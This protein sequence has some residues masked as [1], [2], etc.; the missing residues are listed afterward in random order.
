MVCHLQYKRFLLLSLTYFIIK[1]FTVLGYPVFV[2]HFNRL[3]INTH[4]NIYLLQHTT[5]RSVY[6]THT[7]HQSVNK[8]TNTLL[9]LKTLH[10]LTRNRQTHFSS[11]NSFFALSLLILFFL[12]KT[13]FLNFLLIENSLYILLR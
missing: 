2:T 12:S 13:F 9:H 6:I 1:L 7:K 4:I 11:K 3:V 5:Q 8:H 10:L